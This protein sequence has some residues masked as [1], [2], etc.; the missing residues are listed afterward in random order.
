MDSRYLT[1]NIAIKM[2]GLTHKRKKVEIILP[3]EN[4]PRLSGINYSVNSLFD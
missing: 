4:K 2:H 3:E 1:S